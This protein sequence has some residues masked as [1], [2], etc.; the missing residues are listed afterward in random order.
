MNP[1]LH[2]D[3]PYSKWRGVIH[4]NIFSPLGKY[5]PFKRARDDHEKMYMETFARYSLTNHN[6][7]PVCGRRLWPKLW[8][9]H[10]E[11]TNHMSRAITVKLCL[12]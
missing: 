11:T 3:T 2:I 10:A 6:C 1:A 4:R 8:S 9:R 5:D 7:V 12:E